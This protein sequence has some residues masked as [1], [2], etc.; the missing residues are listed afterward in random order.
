VKNRPTDR[1]EN[2]VGPVTADRP[3]ST[4]RDRRATSAGSG[5]PLVQR[6][7]LVGLGRAQPAAASQVFE[8]APFGGV[9]GD[10]RVEVHGV[11][12]LWR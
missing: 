11:I 6:D 2:T 4:I 3:A 7:Q 10:V 9:L 5:D 12:I 8:P 1:H